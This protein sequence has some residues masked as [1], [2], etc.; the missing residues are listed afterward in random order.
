MSDLK[1]E[2]IDLTPELA[3]H[4]L[5]NKN[6][7]DNRR[8]SAATVKRYARQMTEGRWRLNGQD[9]LFDKEGYLLN[10]QH[11]CAAVVLSGS[12]IRVGVK[13]GV[14]TDAFTSMDQGHGRSGA[15]V[16][17]MRG[18]TNTSLRATVCR[19]VFLWEISRNPINNIKVL[20]D[21]LIL[22]QEV[23]AAEIDAAVSYVDRVRKHG[24][25]ING[26]ILGVGAILFRRA[27]PRKCV[28]FLEVFENGLTTEAG[29]PALV[30]RSKLIK[31][32]M[33][34]RPVPR[35]AQW[36]LLIRAWNYYERGAT[37]RSLNVHRDDAGNFKVP[38]IRGLPNMAPRLA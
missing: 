13:R 8:I 33:K 2:E 21:E 23:Y 4:W 3:K 11:R 36:A 5:S 28:E 10:G 22:A 24:I 20:P 18:Y 19:A 16:M 9:L 12:T 34:H 17:G 27:R 7:S 29:H 35:P 14:E 38:S 25:P 6:Y 30:L 1:Y 37:T 15:S 26:G 31:E 32:K